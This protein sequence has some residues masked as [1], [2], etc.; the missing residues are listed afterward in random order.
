M[1]TVKDLDD[2]MGKVDR[3]SEDVKE[4]CALVEPQQDLN[5]KLVDM[6]KNNFIGVETITPMM[7]KLLHQSEKMTTIK[8]GP[9]SVKT[10]HAEWAFR[11]AFGVIALFLFYK[12][13]TKMLSLEETNEKNRTEFK[14]EMLKLHVQ[15]KQAQTETAQGK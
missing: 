15:D 8:V 11:F 1:L 12:G 5:H 9:L 3:V 13:Y 6:A 4:K 14:L 10:V 7:E 2:R